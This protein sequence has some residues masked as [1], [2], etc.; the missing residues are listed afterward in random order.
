MKPIK[1]NETNRCAR[2]GLAVLASALILQACD[3]D[4][5]AK[6]VDLRYKADDE[7]R[8]ASTTPDP[9]VIQVKSTDPWSVFSNHPDWCSIAPAA[10]EAGEIYDVRIVYADNTGLDDRTDTLTVQ[11]DYWIGKEIRVVQQGT[12]FLTLEE[13]DDFVLDETESTRTFRILSNQDWSAEVTEGGSWLSIASGSTGSANGSVTVACTANKGEKR[14]GA[15]AVR[16][17]HGRLAAEIAVTQEGLQLDPETVYVRAY[18]EKQQIVIPVV[19]NAEWFVVKDDADAEWYSFP[20]ETF[21]GSRDLVIELEENTGGS[22]R[23]A[24][25]T[26]STKLTE[27]VE[28]VT[29]N[30]TIKQ[31]NRSV[32]ERHEFDDAEKSAWTVNNG[33]V[34]F[35]GGNMTCTTGR[36]TRDGFR[37][38]Y[39]SF[40][41]QSLSADAQSTLFFTYGTPEIRWHLNMAT[42]KTN[43]S[44]TPWTPV[45]ENNKDFDKTRGS[46][47]LGL[48]L[49]KAGNGNYKIEWYLDDV[50]MY[51]YEADGAFAVEYD[52]ASFTYLGC[53]A[54]TVVYDWWEYT[55]PIDWGDE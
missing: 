24:T 14:Y 40:R 7:Y 2:L 55:P 54:G 6:W 5:P 17:R 49:L 37:A 30:V 19:S 16:D 4:L 47:T 10:G 8:I 22:V 23:T 46:Y 45:I 32:P 33:T 21:E 20:E 35:A 12:A 31:A 26:L 29:R 39:Y 28:A 38:G 34:T 18:H 48:N 25:F 41:I 3:D 36:V 53:S 15:I 43:Y 51:A 44:T 1:Q 50:L 9:I 13:A 42:G 52:S 27:G 11:S